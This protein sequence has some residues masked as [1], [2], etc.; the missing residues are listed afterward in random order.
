MQISTRE[1]QPRQLGGSVRKHGPHVSSPHA[2]APCPRPQA[3]NQLSG[4]VKGLVAM[5]PKQLAA[6]AHL[7]TAEQ[8]EEIGLAARLP[9]VN[10]VRGRPRRAGWRRRKAALQG[11]APASCGGAGP[12]AA[13]G[14][15]VPPSPHPI[16]S[17]TCPPSPLQGRKRHENRVAQLI[18]SGTSDEA[19]QKLAVRPGAGACRSGGRLAG[20]E[21]K[22]ESV[23]RGCGVGAALKALSRG[24]V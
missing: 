4:V 5:K 24:L 11:R 23:G 22:R 9:R 13:P 14:V 3:N 8:L 21:G 19:I 17:P 18:R 2:R 10:Q 15:P 6:V 16:Y 12:P 1:A 7:L 20:P